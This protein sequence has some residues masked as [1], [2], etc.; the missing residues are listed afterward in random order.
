M[1]CTLAFDRYGRGETAVVL[2][3]G[4]GGGRLIWSDAISGTAS[5]IAAAGFTVIALDLPGY[6]DS[7]LPE[8]PLSIAGMA[9]AARH[10]V[11]AL[12]LLPAVWLGHSMG[13]MVAQELAA[14]DPAAVRGLVLTCTSPAFGKADGAWQQGFLGER[15][16]PLDAGIGMPALAQQ[17]VA[18]M[19]APGAPP[20]A[21]DRAVSVMARVPPTT[22]RAALSA[23]MGF[24]RRAALPD[25]QVPTLVLAAA[26]DKTAPPDVMQRMA[27]KI[28]L[29]TYGCLPAA[30]H[31]AN[32]E[33]P[34]AFH[35]AVVA[36]LKQHFI[37]K[38]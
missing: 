19:V 13:G 34:A 12:G 22:Y 20:A 35:A 4:V 23:L 25:I 8:S 16:A 6:G 30:G 26:Q 5:A 18:R 2:L 37:D 11:Q 33:Q 10:T 36:F 17:L 38:R 28:F 1:A 27:Q 21:I 14:H 31:L 9:A 24:D 7:A 32:V 3:H 15:L 29:S